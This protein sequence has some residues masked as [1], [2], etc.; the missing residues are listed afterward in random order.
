MAAMG[1]YHFINKQQPR[2]KLGLL[3]GRPSVASG[4]EA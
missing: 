3:F 1:E 2:E 4:V